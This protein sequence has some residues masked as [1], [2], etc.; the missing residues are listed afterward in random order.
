[1]VNNG[2]TEQGLFP[3]DNIAL[4]HLDINNINV[5]VFEFSDAA[6]REAIS[7]NISPD[8]YNFTAPDGGFVTWDGVGYPHFWATDNLIVNYWGEDTAVITSLN[9][10]LGQPFADG[11][12]PYLPEANSGAIAGIGEYGVSFQYDPSLAAHLSAEIM[13]GRPSTGPDDFMFDVMPDH[14]AFTFGDTYAADWTIYHQTVNVPNQAQIL[15]FPLDAYASMNQMA[16]EQIVALD[17]VLRDRP[18]LP[19]GALPF[20]PPPN[21]QQD[22][23]AQMA[24]LTF[25]NGEGI[26][27]LTQFNQEPRLINN[28]ETFYTFQGITADHAYYIAAFF[29]IHSDSLPAKD[30]IEDYEAFASNLPNYL[31]Q[32]TADLNALPTTAFTPD[33]ALLDAL[34]Q[35]LLVQPTTELGTETAHDVFCTDIARPAIIAST[36]G[37]YII[38]N[39]LTGEHC[40]LILPRNFTNFSSAN[41]E[42]AYGYSFNPT[43]NQLQLQQLAADGTTQELDF[44]SPADGSQ[45]Y[46]FIL[47]EDGRQLIWTTTTRSD[48][49]NIITSHLW[50]ADLD[51][52]NLAQLV[53]D[54]EETGHVLEPI[55][56]DGETT[57]FHAQWDGIGGMWHSFHGRYDSLYSVKVGSE[58]QKIFACNDHGMMLCVGGISPDNT[59][60]VYTDYINNNLHVVGMDGTLITTIALGGDYS[61]FPT[62][63]PNGD[64][65]YYT[66]VLQENVDGVPLP[67]P[68]TM[69]YLAVPYTGTPRE[70][71]S[72]D[73]LI[74]PITAYDDDHIIINY[75][76][77]LDQWGNALLSVSDGTIAP[78]QPWPGTYYAA[79]LADN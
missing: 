16:H 39:P 15:I 12:Q 4:W 10:V 56:S 9:D 54:W 67:Q 3:G 68:G 72:G 46:S 64:L 36:P 48:D 75:A 5:N 18:D 35:T 53:T 24:Y 38:S 51:G 32:T 25:Q 21:G 34:I 69:Y 28:Q 45:L 57:Y 17:S 65:V 11:S 14:I 8:G 62:F 44:T 23:Q 30:G 79:T 19:N 7:N 2:R 47:S 13:A 42:F 74:Y 40:P 63:L 29:P 50:Q 52:Q 49:L 76:D 55:R 27:Y 41:G 58:P 60:F 59:L 66:A 22:L 73:G 78:L 26:R 37:G 20:L 31:A 33:L 70:I 77:E 71:A 6:A 43:T 1:V 61:G